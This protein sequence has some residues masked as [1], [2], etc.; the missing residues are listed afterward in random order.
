MTEKKIREGRNV[1]CFR[2]MLGMKQEALADTFGDDR[3]QKN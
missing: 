3:N 2:E 1:K